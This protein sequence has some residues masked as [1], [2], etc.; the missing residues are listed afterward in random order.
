[1][2]RLQAIHLSPGRFGAD[3]RHLPG[4]L[5]ETFTAAPTTERELS[6]W[7]LNLDRFAAN[8]LAPINR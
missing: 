4:V 8:R 6:G 5:D 1:M 3:T 7:L 2:A